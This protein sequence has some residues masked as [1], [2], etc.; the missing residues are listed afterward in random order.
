[1]QA[2]DISYREISLTGSDRVALVDACDYERL[3]EWSWHLFGNKNFYAVRHHRGRNI[4]MHRE[5]M[6]YHLNEPFGDITHVN[7]NTLDNRFTNLRIK[8]SS[9][10]RKKHFHATEELQEKIKNRL[11]LGCRDFSIVNAIDANGIV[12]RSNITNLITQS[13]QEL[14][15]LLCQRLKAA[16]LVLESKNELLA[17]QEQITSAVSSLDATLQSLQPK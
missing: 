11:S 2:V 14:N 7:G 8:Y 12:L 3:A 5:I 16:Q 15:H 6:G 4:L 10:P 17:I 13:Q 9:S 1:M